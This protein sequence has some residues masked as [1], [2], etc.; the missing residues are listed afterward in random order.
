MT[1]PSLPTN[2]NRKL[3]TPPARSFGSSPIIQPAARPPSDIEITQR[4]RQAL[5]RERG[6][7]STAPGSIDVFTQ[8]GQVTLRGPIQSE[9]DRSEIEKIAGQV[10]GIG[11]VN[12]QLQLQPR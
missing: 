12:N 6:S 8:N 11:Q 9:A 7:F 4:V 10:N 3:P 5:L 1:N 2:F